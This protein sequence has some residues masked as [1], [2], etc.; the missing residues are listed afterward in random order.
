ME[1]A[2]RQGR[3]LEGIEGIETL[4]TLLFEVAENTE[5]IHFLPT[6]CAIEPKQAERYARMMNARLGGSFRYWFDGEPLSIPDLLAS[7]DGRV[8]IN[9]VN[10]SM[11]MSA[12]DKAYAVA[13]INAA[14][15]EWMRR[16]PGAHRPRLLYCIDEIAQEGGKG[17]IYPP[18]P[19]NPITKPGLTVLLKQGRAFGVSCLLATQN[20][21]DIDYKGLG[22]CDTWIV[23]RLK[24]RI[25]LDRL[26][27]GIEAAQL[28]SGVEGEQ[29]LEDLMTCVA[30]LEPGRF[31]L[32]T[33]QSGTT[34]YRQQW[35]RSLHE[36]LTPEMLRN[37]SRAREVEVDREVERAQEL[38]NSGDAASAMQ[39]LELLLS[40]NPYYTRAAEVR[41]LL[42]DWLFRAERWAELADYAAA[43]RETVQSRAGFDLVHY[44]EGQAHLRLGNRKEARIALERFVAC[45]ANGTTGELADRCRRHLQDLYVAE[46]DF[47]SLEKSLE[48]DAGAADGILGFCRTMKGALLRWP[49]LKGRLDETHV[50]ASEGDATRIRYARKGARSLESY[51]AEIQR[52]LGDLALTAPEVRSLSSEER[53]AMAAISS[54]LTQD[55]KTANAQ[56]SEIERALAEAEA[57]IDERDFVA[58]SEAIDTARKLVRASGFGRDELERVVSL[59]RGAVAAGSESLR[60]W[61]LGL[62]PLRFELETAALFRALGYEAHATRASGDGGVDVYARFENRRFVIQCKRYRHPVPPGVIRELA[63]VVRNEDADSGILVATSSFSAGCRSEAERHGIQL[64][65][66]D[67]LIRLYSLSQRRAAGVGCIGTPTGG[68][69]LAGSG[70]SGRIL[71]TLRAAGEP[72]RTVEVALQCGVSPDACQPILAGLAAAGV[73][74]KQGRGRGVRFSVA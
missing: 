51:A 65:D 24:T 25:D 9:I 62:D 15:I 46:E 53:K 59:Y 18:H 61:L 64:I 13:Q 54:R 60:D 40:R 29:P 58:A 26:R 2:H 3:R 36:R 71:E 7:Q 35:I 27:D 69:D 21:K 50:L 17:A 55:E 37:W 28:E 12:N 33:R 41:L 30:G 49:S 45:A 22:Q 14:I 19:F 43:L 52:R 20:A 32:K 70:L 10:L 48:P 38:W 74:R 23:G 73:V 67:E 4:V 42:C 5:R 57:R 63:T 8:P 39:R 11:L 47:E 1:S 56:R 16:Q 31:L 34:T 6:E 44:F 68:T 72:L 66:I